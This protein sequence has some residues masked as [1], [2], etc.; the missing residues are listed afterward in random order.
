MYFILTKQ[1]FVH[2][3]CREY[4]FYNRYINSAIKTKYLDDDGSG[5]KPKHFSQKQEK[6]VHFVTVQEGKYGI[7]I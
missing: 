6:Y 2:F 4:R 7:E 5:V 3:F 1:I